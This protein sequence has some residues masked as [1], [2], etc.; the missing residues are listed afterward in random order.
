[1][2]QPAQPRAAETARRAREAGEG[3]TEVGS[4]SSPRRAAQARGG[5]RDSG[6]AGR[7]R[8]ASAAARCGGAVAT[9]GRPVRALPEVEAALQQGVRRAAAMRRPGLVRWQ[10]GQVENRKQLMAATKK[11]NGALGRRARRRASDVTLFSLCSCAPF[12]SAR[13]LPRPGLALSHHHPRT[14]SPGTTT[15]APPCDPRF[16]GSDPP[17]NQPAFSTFFF[18]TERC[19]RRSCSRSSSPRASAPPRPA[20]P[21]A[22]TLPVRECV[23]MYWPA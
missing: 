9:T 2:R 11:K 3:K 1:M 6:A 14:G 10:N 15:Q 16:L 18:C 4:P 21:L 17:P 13:G 5:R 19:G 23:C 12:L 22:L 20:A 7:G 8:A